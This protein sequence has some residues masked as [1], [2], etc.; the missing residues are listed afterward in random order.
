MSKRQESRDF[1]KRFLT[2]V[3]VDDYIPLALIGKHWFYVFLITHSLK[4]VW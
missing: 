4:G 2:A 1:D 3:V